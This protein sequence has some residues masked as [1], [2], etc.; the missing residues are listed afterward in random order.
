MS[1]ITV[2]NMPERGKNGLDRRAR[3]T[4]ESLEAFLRRLLE[5][6]AG[7][8]ENLKDI[9]RQFAAILDRVDRL[10]PLT[11][12]QKGAWELTEEFSARDLPA[13]P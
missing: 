6:E 1:S 13:A 7:R 2:R 10:P 9:E 12:G 8:E 3:A 5:A 4:G 11:K